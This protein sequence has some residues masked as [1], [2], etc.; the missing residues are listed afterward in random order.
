MSLLVA[1]DFSTVS[2]A[3]L[4][5]VSRLAHP[6]R[7]VVLLHVAEPDPSFIGMEAGPEEVRGQVAEE[8]RRGRASLQEMADR[9]RAEGHETRALVVPGPTIRTILEQADALGAEVIVVGSHGHGK[10]FDL[11]VGSVSAGVIRKARVPVLVVPSR[12]E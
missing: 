10:L 12:E 11:V 3:Q 6:G 7:E 9:L 8:F 4:T 2:E 1:L 5:I